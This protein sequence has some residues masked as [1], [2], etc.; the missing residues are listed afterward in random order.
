MSLWVKS[1]T[2]TIQMKATEQ[3]FP[4]V[5]F[6]MLYKVVLTCDS[7]DEIHRIE[8]SPTCS[9]MNGFDS[10]LG[11]HVRCAS[12]VILHFPGKYSFTCNLVCLFQS[13]LL[14]SSDLMSGQ[15][16]K[17]RVCEVLF[18]AAWIAGEFSE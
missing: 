1:S 8:E 9:T 4:V 2:A 18:A 3:Y 14:D 6:I 17:N 10:C 5:L 7:V 12:K 11:Q 15:M 13:L 16:E